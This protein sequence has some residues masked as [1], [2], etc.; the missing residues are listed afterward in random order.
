MEL[1]APQSIVSTEVAS[2]LGYLL[3]PRP[4]CFQQVGGFS[5]APS[6]VPLRDRVHPL[7]S[8]TFLQSAWLPL[9][10]RYSRVPDTFL[11]VLFPFATSICEVHLL[12]GFPSTRLRSAHSVLH[13]LGEFLLRIPRGLISSPCHVR[14]SHFREFPRCQAGSP[15]RRVVPSCRWLNSPP[16]EF[17]HRCQIHQPRLQGFGPSSDPLR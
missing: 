11:G 15:H 17:P 1:V 7:T 2:L 3:P 6:P 14:D 13:A 9:T 10:C 12:P 16:G 8:G 5:P 4:R